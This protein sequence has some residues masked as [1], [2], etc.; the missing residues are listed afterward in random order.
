LF[1]YWEPYGV[2]KFGH[3]SV[4]YRH[5][6]NGQIN[7]SPDL[8]DADAVSDGGGKLEGLQVT[9]Q[10]LTGAGVYTFKV[11]CPY[12]ITG[13]QLRLEAD[14]AAKDDVL[15]VE[16]DQPQGGWQKVLEIQGANE[17]VQVAELDKA[18]ARS[19]VGRQD[20]T[21]R[22]TLRGKPQLRRMHLRTWFVHNAMAAPHLMPGSNHVTVEVANE[23]ALKAAPL[24]LVYRYREAPQ[25]TGP[26]VEVKRRIEK[27]GDNFVAELPVT[28]KLP[29]MRDLT[30][31]YGELAWPVSE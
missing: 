31:R 28:E 14:C 30:L 9:P 4:S 23:E 27:N 17:K 15:M 22:M 1:K 21:V 8:T 6:F 5:Y 26:V 24:T 12:Y 25:W 18:V 20:Y 11:R 7:Y 13:G 16:V 10:G 19:N 2:E 29:Q 3:T